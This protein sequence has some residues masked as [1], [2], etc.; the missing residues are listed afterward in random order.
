LLI[1]IIGYGQIIES[2]TTHTI[3]IGS[4]FATLIADEVD[5]KKSDGFLDFSVYYLHRATYFR[6]KR[7]LF[8]SRIL[9]HTTAI[10][11]DLGVA[12]GFHAGY[13]ISLITRTNQIT[14]SAGL[15]AAYV[16][17]AFAEL[18]ILL[19]PFKQIG[20]P[21]FNIRVHQKLR[22][23]EVAGRLD[24]GIIWASYRR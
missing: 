19:F 17:S 12:Y 24:I 14:L 16:S 2:K 15:R 9:R 5:L 4:T 3:S 6:S 18:H 1:P 23:K 13:G 20:I 22:E 8:G 11:L 7:P 10:G 21:G